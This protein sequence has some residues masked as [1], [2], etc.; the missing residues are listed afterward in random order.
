MKHQNSINDTHEDYK[1]AFDFKNINIKVPS[2]LLSQIKIIAIQKNCFTK[3]L[4]IDYL[5]R[6]IKNE[7]KSN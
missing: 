7:S 6:G 5:K 3:D 2:S 1:A 4:I